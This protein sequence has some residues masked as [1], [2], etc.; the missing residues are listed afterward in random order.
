MEKQYV[1][2]ESLRKSLLDYLSARPYGEVAQ[3][4]GALLSLKELI[5][6]KEKEKEKEEKEGEE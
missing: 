5:G 3:G 6:G 1:I 4:I 2:S